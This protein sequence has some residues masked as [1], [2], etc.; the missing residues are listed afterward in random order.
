MSYC[1][2]G[3][4]LVD[5]VNQRQ[6]R[7]DILVEGE[8]IAAVGPGLD[9]GEAQVVPAE[10]LHILPGLVDMHVHLREPG[11][12]DEETIATGLAAA[13]AG[14]FAAVAAM[15]NTQPAI[16]EAALVELVLGRAAAAGSA[17]LYPIGCLTKGQ[18]GK[19]MAELGEMAAAGAVAFSNDGVP[20]GNAE[21]LRCAMEYSKLF[22]LP[23]LLHAEDADLSDGGVMH[24]GVWSTL[25]GL[26]GIPSLAEEAA[27]TRDLLLA[28]ATGA[29]VHICHVST[30]GA[31]RAIREA[32][33]RGVK[34]TAEATPHHLVLTDAALE[35]YDTNA[36]VSPPLRAEADRQALRAALADGTIDAI[37]SDHAPHTLE[38]KHREFGA[39][40]N[41]LV[42]LETSLGLILTE[43]VR[44]GLMTLEELALKMSVNPRR[45]LN[46]PGG[47]ISPGQPAD[48]TLVDL[49][50]VWTV[51]PAT[52]LSKSRNTPFA[53]RQLTGRAVAVLAGGR[54]IHAAAR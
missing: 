44:P 46:L 36:K 27:V 10:G 30:A 18:Q 13:A 49:E 6:A 39:A 5:P 3:G 31:V 17:R 32:K 54:L 37:A 52:F 21:V 43:L 19:E 33:E 14:G 20:L 12:E 2:K 48:L 34:V 42:G 25:L 35:G 8:T 1:L 51:D 11:R 47:E 45:I 23:L 9:P 26:K 40:A 4:I 15:P 16:D 50:R 38:E 22:G 29:A 24:E 28:E 7:L 41:G 53:G